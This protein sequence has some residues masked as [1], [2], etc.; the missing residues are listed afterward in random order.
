M[1]YGKVF[2]VGSGRCGTHWVLNLFLKHP[3]V[4]GLLQ[5]SKIYMVIG[6]FLKRSFKNYIRSYTGKDW[7]SILKSYDS[8]EKGTRMQ[9]F[10][11]RENLVSYIQEIRKNSNAIN[12]KHYQLIDKIFTS[13]FLFHGGNESKTFVEKTPQHIYYV[14]SILK[15]YPDAKIVEVVRDGRDVCASFQKLLEKGT[16]WPAAER[17]QQILNWRN[18]VRK[19][20]EFRSYPKYKKNIILVKYEDLLNSKKDK[21]NQ[22]FKFAGLSNEPDIIQNIIS[23][24]KIINE[25]QVGK[26]SNWRD[27]FSESDIS[28]FEKLAKKELLEL[29]YKW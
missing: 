14:D 2:I 17:E 11:K 24:D 20:I 26:K 1:D 8:Y 7:N 25:S 3:D 21:L 16:R 23:E 29:G 13:F 27:I 5:E 12:E 10:V 4:V 15:Q 19:G 9:M 22:L 6:P 28:L 18:A